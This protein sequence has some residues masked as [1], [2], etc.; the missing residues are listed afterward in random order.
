M[1]NEHS[2]RLEV[3]PKLPLGISFNISLQTR[4]QLIL[5][6]ETFAR[7]FELEIIYVADVVTIELL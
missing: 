6:A 3:P 1:V 2:K 7:H 5:S 4:K